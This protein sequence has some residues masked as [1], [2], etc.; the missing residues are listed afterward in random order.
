MDIDTR[1]M[2]MLGMLTKNLSAMLERIKNE[3]LSPPDADGK[4]R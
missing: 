1:E 4:S 3:R 2:E